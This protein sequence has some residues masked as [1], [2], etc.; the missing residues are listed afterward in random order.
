MQTVNV[1]EAN[2]EPQHGKS[3]LLKRPVFENDIQ[4]STILTFKAFYW[5]NYKNKLPQFPQKK[6]ATEM[7]E[8]QFWKTTPILNLHHT[9]GQ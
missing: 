2:S 5:L 6:S 3:M 7:S 9:E 1:R 4:S 8:L